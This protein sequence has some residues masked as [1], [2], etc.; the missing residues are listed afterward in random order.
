MASILSSLTSP[1]SNPLLKEH[2][3]F[4]VFLLALGS[5]SFAKFVIK[6]A[7][8][9]SQ[10]FILPGKNLKKYGAGKGAWAVVTGASEGIG[11]EFALQ[12]ARKGFHVLIAARNTTSLNNLAAEIEAQNK[13]DNKV[14]TKVLTM[15]FSKP[16]DV[17]QWTRFQSEIEHLDIGVLINNVGRSHSC[18]VD[19]VD[20]PI[21]EMDNILNINVNATVHVTRAIVPGMAKRKRGLVISI[22]SFSG[23]S[24][25]SPMLATYAGTKSFLSSFSAALA[26][27]VKDKGIDV[28]C[29]NTYFVVSNLSKIRK[30]S[31]MIPTPKAYVRSVLAKVGLPCG[32]LFTGRPHVSSPFWSHAMLDWL[33]NIIGWKMFF[34]RYTHDL[35]RSIRK[36]AL[37]KQER[38]AKKQ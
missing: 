12:L 14:Q 13:G 23:V 28:E 10:T 26:E 4:V 18:P 16:N 38:E 1:L 25:V 29:L 3:Y 20:T 19:F 31:V 21:D 6:T 17:A 8:V 5:L 15:D 2:P 36:R 37:R 22:G 30:P 32:A 9:I 35:H 11:R 24:V 33:M 7:G 34:A 27:E